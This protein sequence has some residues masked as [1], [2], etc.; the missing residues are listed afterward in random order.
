MIAG[1]GAHGAHRG[2]GA[3]VAAR[4]LASGRPIHHLGL[5]KDD[6]PRHPLYIAYAR[7]P[8]LWQVKR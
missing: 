5:T 8:E 2:R 1:W 3:V 4:L 7:Q 6:H